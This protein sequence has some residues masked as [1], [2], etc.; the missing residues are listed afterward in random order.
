MVVENPVERVTWFTLDQLSKEMNMVVRNMKTGD[1][2]EPFRTTDSKGNTIYCI[3]RLDNEIQA[4]RAN[5]KDDYQ[6]ISDLA[7]NK[8]K[9]DAYQKWIDNK[10]KRTY[11]KIGDEYRGCSF[12][13]KGW[14]Q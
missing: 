8:K 13:N 5:L 14:I 4:H 11:I 12:I 6:Y 9:N 7:L 1:V 2:S 3:I 10:I